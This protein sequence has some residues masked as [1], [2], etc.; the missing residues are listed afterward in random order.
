MKKKHSNGYRH[1]LK[2]YLNSGDYVLLSNLLKN[3]LK[4]DDN[5]NEKGEYFIRSL[6]FD[7]YEDSA[8]RDKIDGV[9]HR[10][11]VRI[12][13]YNYS[14]TVIKLECKHKESGYIKKQSISLSR[15]EC[16]ALTGGDYRFL[17]YRKEAFARE[18]F[19]LFA[20]RHLRPAV[21]VDYT[22]EA[23]VF[24]VENVRITFDKNIRTGYRSF[25]IFD[26][27]LPT[28]P[29]ADEYD[30]VLEVKF[31]EYLPTFVRS[32]IQ[33]ASHTRSAISKY[34]L[35]RKYEL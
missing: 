12:R 19:T 3:T 28:Y 26:R 32:L 9:D 30:M 24:P 2:Y 14:D 1:E 5:T 27:E 10:Y 6:Y 25:D 22:R 11:K 23:Y 16:D 29:A 7:D 35:S 8:L 13:T 18:M 4:S 15:A 34:V 21:I 17:L 33:T 20:T 31:N